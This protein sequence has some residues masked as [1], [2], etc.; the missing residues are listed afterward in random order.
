ML[1][2]FIPESR[3]PSPGIR[4]LLGPHR[5]L[6]AIIALPVQLRERCAKIYFH[7]K[8]HPAPRVRFR[9]EHVF[10]LRQGWVSA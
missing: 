1:F 5:L 7:T 9:Y 3:S 2:G 6:D 8:R 10:D 4:R